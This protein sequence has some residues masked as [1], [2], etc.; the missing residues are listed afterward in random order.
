VNRGIMGIVGLSAIRRV[1][2]VAVA[3]HVLDERRL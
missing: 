3:A 2:H 1:G